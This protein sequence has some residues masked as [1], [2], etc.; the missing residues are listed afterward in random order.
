VV[1]VHYERWFEDAA[2][3]A[4]ALAAALG[5]PPPSA[6]ALTAITATIRP[7]HRRQQGLPP[8]APPLDRR[9]IRLHRRLFDEAQVDPPLQLAAGPL[10]PRRPWRQALAHRL[11]LLW[12]WQTPL[13]AGP[14]GRG[15]LRR[16]LAI[17]RYRV[18]F[19]QGEG[20][21]ALAC[22]PWLTSRR[23]V[24][25]THQRDPIAWYLRRGW[26]A[27][28]APHP[29]LQ[30]GRLWRETGLRQEAASLYRSLAAREELSPHPRFDPGHYL[31]Q[32]RALGLEPRPTPLEHYLEEGW[33][34][35]L[36]P[37]P[38]VDPVW[39][40]ARLPRPGEPLTL[41]ALAGGDP[42]DPRQTHPGG[43]FFAAAAG[44]PGA[45]AE[46]PLALADLLRLWHRRGLRP[47]ERWLADGAF[48]EPLPGFDLF[49]AVDP[50]L[51]G[52]G[53]HPRPRPALGALAG[54]P[55][56]PGS[57]PLPWRAERLVAA[58][59]DV[60]VTAHADPG[61]CL[62]VLHDPAALESGLA[63]LAAGDG[64]VNLVW[65]PLE[66][67]SVWIGALQG[68][69]GVLDPDPER[70]ALLQRFGVPAA[71]RPPAP[72][73][74]PQDAAAALLH[75]Q[76]RLGLPDPAWLLAANE[77]LELAVLG[78][79]GAERERRWGELSLGSAGERLLLLPRLARIELATLEDAQ[80]LQAWLTRLASK[81]V[82]LL[83]LE[84]PAGGAVQL[85]EGPAELLGAGAEAE[86]LE[87]WEGRQP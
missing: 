86:L 55:P 41:L 6:E 21:A 54:L 78:S 7:Q 69:A 33:R 51:F 46:L 81:S 75:A 29:L 66:Q 44:D 14:A 50:A 16:W 5:L 2:A 12:L 70:V 77:R 53:L 36:A 19:P 71:F 58:W 52:L 65:P 18:L 28:I 84:T 42:E 30:P 40:A 76:L 62:R 59:A 34:L 13:L 8:Q 24:L 1:V 3:Q 20:A 57:T 26:R 31:R 25:L 35:G 37:H 63:A 48:A 11:D 9:L 39:M 87:A 79:S 83:L 27:G 47:A 74:P 85:P 17:R 80:A 4:R 68:V 82:R 38:W 73:P 15:P 64:V 23:P 10:Q 22:L 67:L 60:G 45:A 43:L 56:A 49:G 32:C 61:G 72:L